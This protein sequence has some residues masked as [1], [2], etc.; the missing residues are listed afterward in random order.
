MCFYF[1]GLLVFGH[2]AAKGQTKKSMPICSRM[3]KRTTK[4]SPSG[5]IHG[6]AVLVKDKTVVVRVDDN[7]KIGVRQ[8]VHHKSIISAK[9]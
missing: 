8:R 2:Q 9:S 5:G 4:W 3:S 6:T 1:A 7:V